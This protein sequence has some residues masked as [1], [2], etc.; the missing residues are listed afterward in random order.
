VRFFIAQGERDYQVTTTDYKAW[1]TYWGNRK[2]IT[3]K[4]YPTL[5]HLF[6]E[7]TGKSSPMEYQSE[8]HVAD[9][10]LD[11]MATFITKK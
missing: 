3:K 2:N 4:L 10:L 1:D 8:G 5:N 9:V 7:G 11:D 6:M